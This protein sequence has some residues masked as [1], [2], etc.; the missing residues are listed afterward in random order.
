M[1]YVFFLNLLAITALHFFVPR[2]FCH[3]PCADDVSTFLK[4]DLKINDLFELIQRKS[5]DKILGTFDCRTVHD[6]QTTVFKALAKKLFVLISLTLRNLGPDCVRN[7]EKCTSITEEHA[8]QG[9]SK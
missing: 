2:C 9:G 5:E 4:Y 8:V 3:P 7:C 1:N 6:F